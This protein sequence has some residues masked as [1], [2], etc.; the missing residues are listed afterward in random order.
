MDTLYADLL[1]WLQTHG[2]LG[3]FLF[4]VFENLAIPFPSWLGFVAAEALVK[5]GY[6]TQVSV[7]LAITAG[8]LCGAGLTYYS[9]RA[10]HGFLV[11]RFG[12]SPGLTHAREVL[13]RWYVRY[14]VLA[15]LIGRLL[16]HVRPWASLVAGMAHVPPVRFW[17]WTVIGSLL[18]TA[19]AMWVTVWGWHLWVQYPRLRAAGVIGML[20]IGYGASVY[21]AVRGLIRRR[22]RRRLAR[23]AAEEAERGTGS[24]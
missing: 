7:F 20:A 21:V 15:I 14:G 6:A 3:V 24:L 12:H 1:R 10:G 4:M 8:H 5:A 23:E 9:G 17:L 18:Y 2:M 16:G 11:R 13:Q 19:A 22:R